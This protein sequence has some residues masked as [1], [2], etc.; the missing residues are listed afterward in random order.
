MNLLKKFIYELQEIAVLI[1][2]CLLG[3]RGKPKY[4]TET[5]HQM[6]VIGVQSL[7]I[8]LLNYKV[9]VFGVRT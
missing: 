3:V 2:R 8:I 7:P 6:D 1:W 9:H 5:L 4:Y